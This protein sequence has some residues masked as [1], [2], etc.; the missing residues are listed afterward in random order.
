MHIGAIS[1]PNHSFHLT[2]GYPG[3]PGLPGDTVLLNGSHVR[4]E[5]TAPSVLLLLHFLSRFCL[6]VKCNN[7]LV[8]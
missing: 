3:D 7:I 8:S 6:H 5:T 2:Q 1:F 4:G